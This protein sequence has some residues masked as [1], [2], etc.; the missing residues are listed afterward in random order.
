MPFRKA[1]FSLAV[2]LLAIAPLA[3]AQGTYTQID[4]PSALYTEAYGIDSAGDIVGGYV[5]TSN[6]DH[7]FLL[8]GGVYTT[9]DDPD[10]PGAYA[11]GI[12]DVGQIVGSTGYLSYVY[13]VQTQAFT[14]ISFPNTHYYTFATGI[15]NAGTIVGTLT[16]NGRRTIGFQLTNGTYVEVIPQ[17]ATH[18]ELGGISNLG[19]AVG[20]AGNATGNGNF[21]YGQGGFRLFSVPAHDPTANGIN[22]LGEIVGW[23]V[24]SPNI[25]SQGFAYQNGVFSEV[26]F[27]GSTQGA[28]TSVN[29]SGNVVGTFFDSSGLPHGFTWTPPASSRHRE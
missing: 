24:P 15:N 2:L 14:D 11:Y 13:D 25:N 22:D 9:I 28:A 16:V 12:N 19:V 8:S 23:F 5:D 3:L 26:A 21:L 6:H 4:F 29:N 1:V 20:N 18:A 7:G 27:P 10:E 17:R